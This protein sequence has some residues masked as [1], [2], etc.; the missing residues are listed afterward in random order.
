MFV[1][2]LAKHDF[3]TLTGCGC[4]IPCTLRFAL[5]CIS[6][7]KLVLRMQEEEQIS[8][9][10][11]VA[12]QFISFPSFSLS[13][14]FQQIMNGVMMQI[15]FVWNSA[16]LHSWQ[17]DYRSINRVSTCLTFDKYVPY[18]YVSVANS[19]AFVAENNLK[20]TTDLLFS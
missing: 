10:H 2:A 6:V 1:L 8:S 16:L 14:N 17:V 12:Y 4:C 5:Q 15:S 19:A 7:T 11:C 20:Y 3:G 18:I 9:T 13:L